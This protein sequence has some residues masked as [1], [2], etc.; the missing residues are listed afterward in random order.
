[1]IMTMQAANV[2]VVACAAAVVL[3]QS[4][5]SPHPPTRPPAP[6]EDLLFPCAASFAAT[7]RLDEP[8]KAQ[9]LS[10]ALALPIRG[11]LFS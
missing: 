7:H 8:C 2:V 10:C 3:R 1:V 6:R 9:R 11:Q 4:S 5:A